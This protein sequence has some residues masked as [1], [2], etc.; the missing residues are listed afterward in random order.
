MELLQ[1]IYASAI[2]ILAM[3]LAWVLYPLLAKAAKRLR[4]L[5]PY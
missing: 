2:E 4:R 5:L 3:L 1:L